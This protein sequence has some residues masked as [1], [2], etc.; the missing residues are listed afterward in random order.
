[1]RSTCMMWSIGVLLVLPVSAPA[2]YSTVSARARAELAK[3]LAI[4]RV[5]IGPTRF[6]A[7]GK[8]YA[9]VTF[10][11]TNI[12]PK[13][14]YAYGFTLTANYADGSTRYQPGRGTD[15]LRHY[16]QAG[17]LPAS[18]QRSKYPLLR[19]GETYTD[20]MATFPLGENAA[21]PVMVN[22]EVTMAI[23]E[24]QT[25][26]GDAADIQRVFNGRKYQAENTTG[27]IQDLKA[28]LVA[29]DPRKAGEARAEA[30]ASG[31]ALG[32]DSTPEGLI[33]VKDA[34]GKEVGRSYSQQTRASYLKSAL[35]GTEGD[36]S[37]IQQRI[38]S[39]EEY[40]AVLKVHSV[41]VEAGK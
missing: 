21:P 7:E 38:A 31:R 40:L 30:L 24:D 5:D 12:S 19:P 26:V 10:Q 13:E 14:V 39:S 8:G 28:V 11:L 18:Q 23:F 9:P 2:Q 16:Y 34:Q 32:K 37:R 22:A 17:L 3:V 15:L 36:R 33:I 4:Q 41:R 20:S 6:S 25:A 1:M 29:D 35:V 27:L